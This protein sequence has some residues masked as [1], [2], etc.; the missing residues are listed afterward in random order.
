MVVRE[1]PVALEVK[2]LPPSAQLV[3]RVS[4]QGYDYIFDEIIA[5]GPSSVNKEL[6]S[7]PQG[8]KYFFDYVLH[9]E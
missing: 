3:F 5:S 8:G 9:F 7:T 6:C 4:M 1:S 2:K